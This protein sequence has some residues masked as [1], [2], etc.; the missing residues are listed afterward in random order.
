MLNAHLLKM[1]LC[2]STEVKIIGM[3]CMIP[4]EMQYQVLTIENMLCNDIW[5]VK[6]I[7]N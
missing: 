4:Q 6:V 1:F 2:N 3:Q 7:K 5:F